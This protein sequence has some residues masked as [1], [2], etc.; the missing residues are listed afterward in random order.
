MQTA[1]A[2]R[3]YDHRIR[4]AILESGERDLFPELRIPPST[5][6]SWFHRGVPEVTTAERA[7]CDRAALL[8]E[9]R[10]L[11]QRMAL[12]AGVVGLM[13]TM[14]RVS[15]NPIER[16]RAPDAKSKAMLLRAVERSSRVLPLEAALGI[17]RLSP[18]RYPSWRQRD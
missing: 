4:E 10:A 3:T 18:S 7:S 2:Q 6:R 14:L 9:I 11:R 1:H 12:L 5:I 15:K 8:S 13:T 17:T 16:D